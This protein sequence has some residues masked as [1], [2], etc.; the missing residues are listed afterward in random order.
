MSTFHFT[1]TDAQGQRIQ[2]EIVAADA[3]AARREVLARGLTLVEILPMPEARPPSRLSPR[4]VEQ[5]V[6]ALA[7]VSRSEMPL[8]AGL[9]AAAQECTSRRVASALRQIATQIEQGY[10]LEAILSEHGR[11][12]PPHVRGLIAAA[13]RSQRLGIALD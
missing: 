8:A 3:S 9:R 13:A 12:L 2:G 5:V 6:V 4:D 1:A 11:Y 7:E 10:A